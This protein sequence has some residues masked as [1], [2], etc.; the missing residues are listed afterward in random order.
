METNLKIEVSEEQKE[1]IRL[2]AFLARRPEFLSRSQIKRLIEQDRVLVNS[3]K[4]K[5]ATKVKAGDRVQVSIP[6]ARPAK[7]EPESIPLKI[8]YQD[9]HLAVIDKPAGLSTHPAPGKMTGTL[10]NAL[11][12]LIKDLS[13]IGGVL[14]PGIVHRLD[15]LTSGVMV[16][17]K[18]DRG[19]IGLCSQFREHDIE[20]A[21]LALVWGNMPK[22]SGRIESLIGRNPA[23]RLKMTGRTGKGRLAITEW[24]LKKRFK[25]FALVECRLFTGRTHQ[26]RVHMTEAGHPLVGDPLYGRRSALSQKLAPEVRS[27]LQNL[28][29][30][31]LHAYKLGF[32]HPLTGQKMLFTSPLPDDMESVI[33]RL[34]EFDR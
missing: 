28:K 22:E 9:E 17:A 11:L 14:K 34:E 31:A 8:I 27:A 6:E 16:I 1:P 13:G 18:T 32:V 5:P 20:R 33:K 10:V 19:H 12:Y 29:R 25:H 4:A 3:R 7:P 30:Q 21:Y 2:D 15:K 26:I 23:H 24:K